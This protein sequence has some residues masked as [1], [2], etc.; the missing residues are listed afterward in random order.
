M[1]LFDLERAFKAITAKAVL[2]TRYF[3]Y[4]DGVQPLVYSSE[5]LEEAF[6][7]IKARFNQNWC[8]VVLNS[9]LDRLVLKGFDPAD[10]AVNEKID[11]L[12]SRYRLAVDAY[13]VHRDALISGEG[14][15]IAWREG[16]VVD[17][18]RNDPRMVQLFYKTDRPKV[19]DFGAKMYVDLENGFTHMVLYYADHLEYYVCR[20]KGLP[21]SVKAFEIEMADGVNPFGLVPVFRFEC[22]G[23]ELRDIMTLQDAIN[24]LTAD[25]MVAAEYGAFRQRYVIT[26]ADT[27]VLQNGPNKIWE[28]PA[29]DGIGQQSQVG[30]F[31][32]TDLKNYTES[33]D[34]LADKVAI[35][36]RTPKHYLSQVGGNI[37]GDALLAMEAPLVKKVKQR[38]ER[39]GLTWQELGVFLMALEGIVLSESRLLPVWDP[40]ASEQLITDAQSLQLNVTAGIPLET[41]LRRKGWGKEEI[42]QLEADRAEEKVRDATTATA[43][44]ETLRIK[45][46][47]QNLGEE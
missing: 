3:Q 10:A 46:D 16:D 39:F 42:A 33:I 38:Q 13:D 19:K 32:S 26:N 21:S 34:N 14:Y 30:E 15:I 9:T 43:L 47:A 22:P 8:A 41:V 18:Y 35:I 6:S 45:S 23:G 2:M 36:S 4:A 5:R 17:V 44:L 1:S 28:I 24:K 20:K 7:T 11:E 29:G 12:W 40:A 27:S 25:M 31:S 37:S